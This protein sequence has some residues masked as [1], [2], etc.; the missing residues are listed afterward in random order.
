MKN[1]INFPCV[2][3]LLRELQSFSNTQMYNGENHTFIFNKINQFCNNQSMHSTVQQLNDKLNLVMWSVTV[4]R[5]GELCGASTHLLSDTQLNEYWIKIFLMNFHVTFST[6][7]LNLKLDQD[8]PSLV[9]SVF[10]LLSKFWFFQAQL[11]FDL[12]A[13]WLRIRLMAHLSIKID[14]NRLIY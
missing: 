10:V 5:L 9:I 4:S 11:S 7:Y 13:K 1:N 6:G 3:C 12:V 14:I 8:Y 2:Y